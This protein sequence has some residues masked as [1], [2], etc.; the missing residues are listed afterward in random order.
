MKNGDVKP[1]VAFDEKKLQDDV[2]NLDSVVDHGFDT[3]MTNVC[4]VFIRAGTDQAIVDKNYNA[5]KAILENQ[6]LQQTAKN[7]GIRLDIRD[8][9]AVKDYIIST[10]TKAEKYSKLVK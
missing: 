10:M 6:K 4:A 2:Y 9:K 3:W 8:G 5:L 1:V 7:I